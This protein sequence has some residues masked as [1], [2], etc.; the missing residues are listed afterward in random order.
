MK[1][2]LAPELIVSKW[3]N[4]DTPLTLQK[5]SGKV[6]VIYAFQMLCPGC[7]AKAIPQA[8]SVHALFSN[9]PLQ[10]IG[11]HTVFEH[12]NA[13]GQE[14]LEA[15]IHEYRI[16]FPVAIDA[17]SET[18]VAA[19]KTMQLYGMQGTPTVIMIDKNGIL[20]KNAFGHQD[21]MIIGAEIMALL[22]E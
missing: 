20:R 13:M 2:E 21:D 3:L 1:T 7:V 11:L 9:H 17:P 10:V 4:T 12:H 6:V 22:K 19:P 18:K 16:E 14:A 5:L 8:A 15:F